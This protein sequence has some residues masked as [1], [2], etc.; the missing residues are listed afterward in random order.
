MQTDMH[1][2]GTYAMARA[3]GLVPAVCQ[4]IATAAEFVD[5]NGDKETIEFPDGG[6]LDFVPTAHHVTD[7]VANN[8]RHDQRLIW[9]PFHFLPGNEGSS[10]S[11]RLICR[12]NSRIARELVLHNLSSVDKPF[13]YHLAGITAHVYA[14]TFSHYGFSGVSSRWNRIDSSSLGAIDVQP[15]IA[16]YIE[17]K[18]A[19]FRERYAPEMGGLPNFRDPESWNTR[20]SKTLAALK[21]EMMSAGAEALS[22]ALGHGAALTYP[23]RPYLRWKFDYEHPETRSSGMR[24]NPATFCEACEAIHDMFRQLARRFPDAQQDEGRDFADIR[25]AVAR[26]LALQAPLARRKKAWRDAASAGELFVRAESI[27]PYRGASWKKGLDALKR[28]K[29][30]TMVSGKPIFRF[31]QAAAIHRTFVLR[32]LL[33]RHGVVAD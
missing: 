6:R 30:S 29:A 31:F 24:D 4:T 20:L 9:L 1:Y 28:A 13:G 11:E 7:L 15:R 26:I 19:R 10:M 27:L 3:A 12:K 8:D 18:A 16:R 21:Q 5:D 14:D 17:K 25:D 32:D 2:F 23:D 33:P 22:G